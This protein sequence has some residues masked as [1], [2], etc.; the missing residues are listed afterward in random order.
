MYRPLDV[1]FSEEAIFVSVSINAHLHLFKN[2]WGALCCM[3]LFELWFYMCK[4]WKRFN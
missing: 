4:N 3:A 2:S 1:P